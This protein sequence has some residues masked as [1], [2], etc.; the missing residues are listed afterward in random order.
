MLGQPHRSAKGG[1]MGCGETG[2]TSG[3]AKNQGGLAR[4]RAGSRSCEGHTSWCTRDGSQTNANSSWFRQC[5]SNNPGISRP[6]TCKAQ[7]P[8][9]HE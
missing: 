2:V 4:Q 5:C 6:S 3:M 1:L 8:A 7:P 9:D